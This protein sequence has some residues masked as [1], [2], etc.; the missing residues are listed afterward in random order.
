MQ[1]IST[2]K[3]MTGHLG[4]HGNLF[5]GQMLAWLD[6][7]GVA[8]ASEICGTPRMVTV[9]MAEVQFTAPARPTQIIKI[10]G[11]VERMG[12]TSVV[13][14]LEARR[15]SVYN[16]TQ[17]VICKTKITFVRI[18]GDGEPVPIPDHMRKAWL[19]E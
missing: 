17:K 14:N 9:H 5:G 11:A 12:T 13:L 15:H 19:E 1:L 2:H 4:Y 10:Y 3:V 16:G 7:A 18:D 6:E 8:F